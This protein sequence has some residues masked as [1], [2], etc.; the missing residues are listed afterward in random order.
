MDKS[1]RRLDLIG[2]GKEPPSYAIAL[3]GDPLARKRREGDE[4]TPE[5]V[6]EARS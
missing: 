5:L 2:D 3:G 1:D 4:R 6:P